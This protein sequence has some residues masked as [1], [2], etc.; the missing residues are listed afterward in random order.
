MEYKADRANS[1]FRLEIIEI[2]EPCTV[3]WESMTGDDKVRFCSQC[4]KNVYNLS[5]LSTAEARGLLISKEG[6]ICISMLKR[7]DGTIVSDECPRILKPIRDGYR[8]LT[9]AISAVLAISLSCLPARS[10]ENKSAA[11]AAKVPSAAAK[12]ADL[13]GGARRLGGKPMSH[14][15]HSQMPTTGN[16]KQILIP[17]ADECSG[18]NVGKQGAGEQPMRNDRADRG[19]SAE[20]FRQGPVLISAAEKSHP[21]DRNIDIGPYVA[22]VK[23]R[24]MRAWFPAKDSRKVVLQFHLDKTGVLIGPVKVNV[25][26]G[27][28]ADNCALKAVQEAAPFRPLPI[29][30]P[31]RIKVEFTFGPF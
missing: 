7:A 16:G 28:N 2:P 8:R 21:L 15:D 27:A 18:A 31:D 26:G 1:G 10:Q 23:R 9:A 14:I 5:S 6:E 19:W 25:S 12:D 20:G 17:A 3:P 22:D 13:E 11:G 29:G 30:V 4:T 24:V